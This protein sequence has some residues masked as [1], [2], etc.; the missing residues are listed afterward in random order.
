MDRFI[1]IT[2]L[3]VAISGCSSKGG[4]VKYANPDEKFI[5][6][7]GDIKKPLIYEIKVEY[8]T[9]SPINQCTNYHIALGKDVAQ[10]YEFNYQPEIIE[11][12]HSIRVPLKE[13][14]PNTLCKWKPVMAFVCIGSATNKP[15]SCTSIFSFRGIQDIDPVTTLECS[16]NSFCFDSKNN[17]RSGAINEFNKKY[18]LNLVLK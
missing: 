16:E 13:L 15:T 5:D 10:L 12:L 7:H 11:E 14:D 4:F 9:H 17:I 8:R 3:F 1:F 18:Q 6:I 2:L